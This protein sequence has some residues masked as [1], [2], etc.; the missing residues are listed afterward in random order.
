VKTR[1]FRTLG[2]TCIAVLG[3]L[4]SAVALPTDESDSTFRSTA[5]R[6][7]SAR[8]LARTSIRDSVD[9]RGQGQGADRR[10]TPGQQGPLCGASGAEKRDQKT[11]AVPDMGSTLAL[12]GPAL[13]GLLVL[14]RRWR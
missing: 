5:L 6:A 13:A 14:R 10:C 8:I 9:N 1:L 3:S 2:A 12:L 7:A 4:A 11:V